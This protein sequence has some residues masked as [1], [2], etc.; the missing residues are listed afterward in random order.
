MSQD[1]AFRARSHACPCAGQWSHSQPH[2]GSEL[3]LWAFG[4]VFP[5]HSL[6]GSGSGEGDH[7]SSLWLFWCSRK[8]FFDI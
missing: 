3:G 7:A 5:A 1:R 8:R 4:L 2:Q 6:P